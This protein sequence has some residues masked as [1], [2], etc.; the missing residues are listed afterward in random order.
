MLIWKLLGNIRRRTNAADRG[1]R[2]VLQLQFAKWFKFLT[3]LAC[4]VMYN[5][6]TVLVKV[7]INV[8]MLSFLSSFFLFT[9]CIFWLLNVSVFPSCKT[10]CEGHVYLFLNRLFVCTCWHI[11]IYIYMYLL[12]TTLNTQLDRMALF[13]TVVLLRHPLVCR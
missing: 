1:S 10:W 4:F 11:H 7:L 8:F 9:H 2:L 5:I 6:F 3:K 12:Y 13:A